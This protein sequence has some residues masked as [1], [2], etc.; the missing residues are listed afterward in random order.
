MRC[1]IY[2]RYSS[3]MQKPESIDDQIRE[4]KR[5][6][7]KRGW[8]VSEEHIYTDYAVTGTDIGRDGYSKLKDAAL[9]QAFDFIVVDD[10]SQLGRNTAESIHTFSELTFCGVHIASVAD[11]IDTSQKGAKMPFHFKSIMNE[12]FLDDLRDKVL[13]GQKGQVER[14]YSAG[15][16]LYGYTYEEVLDPSGLK[17]KMGRVK[18]TG[19]VVQIDPEQ[20]E[21]VKKI[22]EMRAKGCGLR[23]I[24]KF[25]NES[26]IIPPQLGK[27]NRVS[28]TWC[29][30]SVRTI[31]RNA[32]YIGDWTWNKTKWVKCPGSRKRKRIERPREE[33]VITRREELRIV[34]DSLWSAVRKMDRNGV[35]D[36]TRRTNG[37]LAGYYGGNTREKHLFSGLLKCGVCGGNMVV[38]TSKKRG[39]YY[40]CGIHRTR[41]DIGCLNCLRVDRGLVETML[42]SGISKT[43]LNPDTL[44][45]IVR[46]ANRKLTSELS[47]KHV[48]TS[49][50]ESQRQ[51]IAEQVD[52]LTAFIMKGNHSARVSALLAQKEEELAN[53]ERQLETV[54]A[55]GCPAAEPIPVSWVRTQVE[56]LKELFDQYPEKTY[57]LRQEIKK[58]LID[59]VVMRPPLLKSDRRGYVAEVNAD[60]LSLWGTTSTR[61][62]IGHSATGIRTPV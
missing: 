17:D 49:G 25:L 32:K 60:P 34:P 24:A 4:C 9:R 51:G 52:N 41:G 37:Q 5:Y 11:G 53:I 50:L 36:T 57:L 18:R 45:S 22:F 6:A 21:V 27:R 28:V 40:V 62:L 54:N 59:K 1:A 61:S 7:E 26:K 3:D 39:S 23:A 38:V 19:V 48:G 35:A 31:L 58:S 29:P 16:R 15:G 43:M 10:L 30:S 8:R 42:L 12:F 33:W 14:G 20:A 44:D 55:K 46:K 47:R 13:R 56:N 2:A